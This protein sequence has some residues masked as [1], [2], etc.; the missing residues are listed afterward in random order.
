MTDLMPFVVLYNSIT[1]KNSDG[2]YNEDTLNVEFLKKFIISKHKYLS[3]KLDKYKTKFKEAKDNIN[4]L[5][6]DIKNYENI[7]GQMPTYEI[8]K[9]FPEKNN[10][11]DVYMLVSKLYIQLLSKLYLYNPNIVNN[12]FVIELDHPITI[13]LQ[14]SADGIITQYN[15]DSNNYD[16]LYDLIYDWY[17]NSLGKLN[18]EKENIIAELKNSETLG[19]Q[20]NRMLVTNSFTSVKDPSMISWAIISFISHFSDIYLKVK[21]SKNLETTKE[22]FSAF[23]FGIK[24]IILDKWAKIIYIHPPENYNTH[25]DLRDIEHIFT[26]IN[27]HEQ[28]YDW[29]KG[30]PVNADGKY[31]LELLGLYQVD[32]FTEITEYLKLVGYIEGIPL[33]YNDLNEKLTKIGDDYFRN[34]SV[35]NNDILIEKNTEIRLKAMREYNEY[36]EDYIL[37]K[38]V[39]KKNPTCDNCNFPQYV[40]RKINKYYKTFTTDVNTKQ[41]KLTELNSKIEDFKQNFINKLSEYILKHNTSI[42]NIDEDNIGHKHLLYSAQEDLKNLLFDNISP[43]SFKNALQ[44][45]DIIRNDLASNLLNFIDNPNKFQDRYLNF[46]ITGP[47]GAGK[48]TLANTISQFLKTLD[49]LITGKINTVTR[50]NLIGQYIGQTAPLTKAWLI[51]SSEGILFID[52]AYQLA[53][54]KTS[55]KTIKKIQDSTEYNIQTYAPAGGL[56][57]GNEAITEIVNYLDKNIGFI[58]VMAAGYEEQINGC[59]LG[60]NEGMPRRFPNKYL[61]TRMNVFELAKVLFNNLFKKLDTAN[62]AIIMRYLII[63]HVKL[64]EGDIPEGYPFTFITIFIVYLIYVLEALDLLQNGP[65]DL[66]N[67]ANFIYIEI[68]SNLQT[69][70]EQILIRYICAGFEKLLNSK[71]FK[72]TY[73][74]R[75]IADIGLKILFRIIPNTIENKAKFNNN[76]VEIK[77]SLPQ[78]LSD[79]LKWKTNH[80]DYVREHLT[81]ITF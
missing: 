29:I 2:S 55:Y 49:L 35:Y 76:Q 56:D 3:W 45:R 5:K 80:Y 43:Y 74:I 6:R 52:E 78:M 71:G 34:V 59:F 18:T 64:L 40:E 10:L 69:I 22:Q 42:T 28:Y 39:I 16:N 12:T 65:G 51:K 41:A 58:C 9:K 20:L 44:G 21:K 24:A 37:F 23:H 77:K 27:N 60:A 46:V 17:L 61:I 4:S 54:C 67:L 62:R 14:I 7:N 31:T 25:Y 15:C 32:I 73:K 47:A 38:N 26:H 48:T 53:G 79:I 30:T 50:S 8:D 70:D 1:T 11:D 63:D 75:E 13:N 57:F 19:N 72:F 81:F 36:I 66:Q 68:P 33:D